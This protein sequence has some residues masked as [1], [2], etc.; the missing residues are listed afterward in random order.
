MTDLRGLTAQSPLVADIVTPLFYTE[1]PSKK[2]CSII[3]SSITFYTNWFFSIDTLGTY[4]FKVCLHISVTRIRSVPCFFF[5]IIT[6]EKYSFIFEWTCSNTSGTVSYEDRSISLRRTY[7]NMCERSFKN[8]RIFF[9]TGT[10]KTHAELS[11][12]WIGTYT[13]RIYM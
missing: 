1:C 10:E 3:L 12:Y 4:T 2:L 13:L 7:V 11:R 9:I 6:N 5:F 8:K